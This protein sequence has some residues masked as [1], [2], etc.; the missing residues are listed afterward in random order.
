MADAKSSYEVEVKTTGDAS[1]AKEVAKGIDAI[2]VR[3]GGGTSV[4]DPRRHALCRERTNPR[5]RK[6]RRAQHADGGV[7]ANRARDELRRG[8]RRPATRAAS[9]ST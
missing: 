9:S 3:V 6:R 4:G 8:A 2:G 5:T 1:G 7:A